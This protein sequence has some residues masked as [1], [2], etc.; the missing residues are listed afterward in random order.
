MPRGRTDRVCTAVESDGTK[1]TT[2]IKISKDRDLCGKHHQRFSAYGHVNLNPLPGRKM[3]RGYIRIKSWGHPSASV[4][5]YVAEHRLVMEAH[6]GRYLDR[7]EE[8][9]HKNGVR[10][11]NRIEN[12]ELWVVSQPKGQR[13]CDLVEWATEILVL[14]AGEC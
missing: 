13:P 14:Y 8:V 2:T 10:G 5:G 1:C 6:M 11:D 7:N 4:D 12:L 9:H 3:E